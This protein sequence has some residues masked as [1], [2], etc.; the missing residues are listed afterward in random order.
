MFVCFRKLSSRDR[1]IVKINCQPTCYFSCRDRFKSNSLVF[2]PFPRRDIDF[3]SGKIT[4]L[5]AKLMFYFRLIV[6]KSS[7]QKL[8]RFVH[9]NTFVG[10]YVYHVLESCTY[11]LG[12]YN[13]GLV[14][15]RV[16]LHLFP[17]YKIRKSL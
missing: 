13:D 5:K 12:F 2:E 9:F 8:L 16:H 15:M 3:T 10:D 17:E 6:I 11:L 4:W 14:K 1:F 7:I